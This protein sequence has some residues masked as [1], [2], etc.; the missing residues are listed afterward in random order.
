MTAPLAPVAVAP[1]IFTF[2]S[3]PVYMDSGIAMFLAKATTVG[4]TPEELALMDQAKLGAERLVVMR[5]NA[6]VAAQRLW[7]APVQGRA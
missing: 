6:I 3:I 4:T 5:R 1:V 2:L 7:D